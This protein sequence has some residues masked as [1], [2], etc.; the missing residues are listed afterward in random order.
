MADRGG[1]CRSEL[2]REKPE[3]SA[4]YQAP[5]VIVDRHREQARS[6][7]LFQVPR[8]SGTIGDRYRRNGNVHH[9]QN[10]PAMRPPSPASRLLQGSVF[11]RDCVQNLFLNPGIT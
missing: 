4:G 11:P 10:T 3:S 5:R 6:Y 1:L 2:A 8:K 7:R 9:Q